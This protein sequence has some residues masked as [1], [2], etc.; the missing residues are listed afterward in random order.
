MSNGKRRI[1]LVLLMVA[2]ASL[3]V[4]SALVFNVSAEGNSVI[5]IGSGEGLVGQTIDIPI[6]ISNAAGLTSGTI[7]IVYD[8]SIINPTSATKGP[9]VEDATFFGFNPNYTIGTLPPAPYKVGRISWGYTMGGSYQGTDDVLCVL[10]VELMSAGVADVTFYENGLLKAD[11][12]TLADEHVAGSITVWSNKLPQVE[13]PT[14]D[15]SMIKWNDIDHPGEYRY[16]VTLYKGGVEETSVEVNPGVKEYDFGSAMDGAKPGYFTATVQ[17]L[18]EPGS[19]YEDGEPSVASAEKTVSVQLGKVNQPWWGTGDEYWTIKWNAVPNATGYKVYLYRGEDLVNSYDVGNVTSYNLDSYTTDAGSYSVEV[20][21]LG[22]GELWLDGPNSDRSSARVRVGPLPDVTGLD[23]DITYAGVITWNS[24]SGAA[25]YNVRLHDSTDAV[26]FVD[27]VNAN[28]TIYD[29][30]LE[31]RGAGV[32]SYY[33]SIKAQGDGVSSLDSPNWVYSSP[34][35]IIQL[36]APTNLA[37]SD[38]GM[39]SWD[40]VANNSG[41]AVELYHDSQY[42]AS[43]GTGKSINSYDFSSL[44]RTKGPGVYHLKV[45]ALGTGYYLESGWANSDTITVQRLSFPSSATMAN[46]Q[47]SW[48]DVANAHHYKLELLYKAPGSDTITTTFEDDAYDTSY[49][50]LP[51]MREAAGSYSVKVQTMGDPNSVLYLDSYGSAQTI[52]EDVQALPDPTGLTWDDET[53]KWNNITGDAA[54]AVSD[55]KVQLRLGGADYGDPVIAT[56]GSTGV[57]F[58]SLMAA[59]GAGYYTATVTAIAK[60]DTLYLDS[61]ATLSPEY[62]KTGPLGKVAQPSLSDTGVVTWED[63]GIATYYQVRLYD[64]NDTE[65]ASATMA[66]GVESCSFLA[67]MRNAG[68]GTYY[69]TVQALAT[70]LELYEDGP[71]SAASNTQTVAV[72]ADPVVTFDGQG[73]A[74]WSST[75][76]IQYK[77]GLYR[78]NVLVSGTEETTADT[79]RNYLDLMRQAPGVYTIKVI[80]TADPNT[81]FLNSGEATSASQEVIQLAQAAKP[82]LSNMGVA[83]WDAVSN[84]VSYKLELFKDGELL[85]T[86]E[87]ANSPCDLLA[88]ILAAGEGSYT[89]RVTAL[90]D[91]LLILDGAQS[92]ASDPQTVE[93]LAR[94]DRPEWI[95][96]G[97]ISWPVVGDASEY[98]VKLYRGDE[99]VSEHTVAAEAGPVQTYEVLEPYPPLAGFYN[100]T[101]QALGEGMKLDGEPSPNSKYLVQ[102]LQD[103]ESESWEADGLLQ[104]FRKLYLRF[105]GN[106]YFDGLMDLLFSASHTTGAPA[107]KKA[108]GI[109]LMVDYD[110]LAA[111]IGT[112]QEN[113]D[114]GENGCSYSALIRIY[115][116]PDD[117]EGLK[118]ESLRLYRLENGA[119]VQL[120]VSGIGSDEHGDYVWGQVDGFSE[121]AIFGDAAPTPGEEEPEEPEKPEEPLPKTWG[122][123]AYTFFAGLLITA[124][125]L[126]VRRARFSRR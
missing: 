30:L 1:Q 50:M 72:L 73:V 54:A 3:I 109:Y 68:A 9:L 33:V 88:D 52:W 22:D 17:A 37:L 63:V 13:Q 20:Q 101:V 81:L 70:G 8:S 120:A 7:D 24:V 104:L 107:G 11:G 80:A 67:A 123:M 112:T 91:E 106:S 21:A 71:E 69:A 74:G 19:E 51:E 39:G 42:Y 78:D 89:V 4:G 18:A 115:L 66:A 23:W 111:E 49:N 76:A 84:A 64:S 108:A 26:I 65:I 98:L 85:K 47:V 113:G 31:M 116:E 86:V 29:M 6:E 12:V 90:G 105:T 60:T 25:G 62:T 45:K 79:T 100:V 58:S 82:A 5:T 10:K 43:I 14:W 102:P 96:P 87:D 92:V 40:N 35:E 97:V 103:E 94:V 117:I 110:D 53:L 55:Y 41:Y 118:R 114:N 126:L 56:D 122:L 121:F 95:G 16:L 28:T 75:G 34:K 124:A 15:G 38:A 77:V 119:W 93:T 32:G 99:F 57:D 48:P 36:A 2:I 59:G 61:G 46:G 83:T 44:I 27:T 125:G